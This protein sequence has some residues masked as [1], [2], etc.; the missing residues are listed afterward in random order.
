M[1]KLST[2][3]LLL[4]FIGANSITAAPYKADFNS[5]IDTSDHAFKPAQ[6]WGH[7]V[8]GFQHPF[9][10]WLSSFTEYTY[11]HYGKCY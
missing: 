9:W 3:L 7:I 1:K 5:S 4:L 8:D 11:V 6:G 10:S 2:L